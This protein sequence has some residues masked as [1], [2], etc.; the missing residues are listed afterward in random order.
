MKKIISIG[1]LILIGMSANAQD[2]M[3]FSTQ[4]YAGLL[5]GGSENALQIQTINGI[6]VNKWFMGIGTGIDWY[7]VRSVPLFLLVEKGFAVNKTKNIYF[8][9]GAGSNFPWKD[10]NGYADRWYWAS[11]SKTQEG[12]YLNAGVGYKISVGKQNDAVLLHLGYSNKRYKEKITITSP[13][14][15]GDCPESTESFNNDLRAVSI[16]IGYGF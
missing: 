8:S 12:L 7:Y 16:K 13:C 4:N 5:A 6:A 14:L 10:K 11:D 15:W 3:R 1:W 2:K 9:A